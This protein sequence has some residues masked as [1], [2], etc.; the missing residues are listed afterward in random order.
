MYSSH[1]TTWRRERDA[2][3]LAALTPK[4]RGRKPTKNPLADE[5]ARLQR[6][7]ERMK[8][9]L[10]KAKRSSTSRG[11]RTVGGTLPEPTEEDFAEASRRFRPGRLDIAPERRKP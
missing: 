5:N 10:D 6:E 3:E 11:S 8:K 1:L 9:E 2:G 4:K 7:L